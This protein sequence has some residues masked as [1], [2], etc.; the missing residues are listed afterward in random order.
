M[1]TAQAAGVRVSFDTNFR[2]SLWSIDRARA[3]MNDV[4][5][6]TDICLPSYDDVAAITGLAE[7]HALVDHCL[8]LGARIVALKLGSRGVIVADD[9]HRELIAPHPCKP[10]DATGAGDAF[11]GAFVA[12]LV[13]GDAL[14]VAARYAS[15]AAAISTEGYGAVDPI[16]TADTVFSALSGQHPDHPGRSTDEPDPAA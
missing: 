6:R 4:M 9:S 5:S 12:R 8:R 10:V 1:D 15:V 3:V 14:A 2:R 13:A 11:G 7:P 16:P